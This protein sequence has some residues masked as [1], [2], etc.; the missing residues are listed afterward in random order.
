MTLTAGAARVELPVRGP[1]QLDA[2]LRPFGPPESGAA[3]AKEYSLQGPTGRVVH[4]DLASGTADVEFPWID[5]RHVIT[6]SGTL[7]AERNV[8]H[9]AVTEGDPLSAAV[10]VEVDLELGRG[11]WQ[12]S[13]QVRSE[14]TCD[15]ERFLVTTEL[16]AYEGGVRRFGR[17]WEQ[18]I[19][20]DGG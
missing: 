2:A 18:A 10:R 7:L 17:R 8:A 20:R 6:D 9:Y 13:V 16:D 3:L 19:P 14:M 11:D 1:S 5:H 15:R 12:T 4:H